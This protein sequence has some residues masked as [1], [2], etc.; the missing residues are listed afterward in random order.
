MKNPLLAGRYAR[1]LFAATDGK[2][3]ISDLVKLGAD[4]AKLRQPSLRYP[5]M[6]KRLGREP[7]TDP[8]RNLLKLLA[9]RKRHELIPEIVEAY[10]L[11]VERAAGIGR[12]EVTAASA[13][14]QETLERIKKLVAGLMQVREVKLKVRE[15]KELVGG[16]VIKIGDNLFD[17]SVRAR[18]DGFRARF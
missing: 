14:A 2:A 5:E 9:R 12:A 16:M 15:E 6:V 17:G 11:C 7:A 10:N 13:L 3:D 18:L 4:P 1:A 8:I